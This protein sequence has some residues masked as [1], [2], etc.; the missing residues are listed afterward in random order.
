MA[1]IVSSRLERTIAMLKWLALSSF[2]IFGVV[3][4]RAALRPDP[5][6]G[7]NEIIDQI[8]TLKVDAG[9]SGRQMPPTLFG[10]FFEVHT[11]YLPSKIWAR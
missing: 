2:L 7:E 11:M 9:H 10:I 6:N 4:T 3:A 8:A 1:A 5:A